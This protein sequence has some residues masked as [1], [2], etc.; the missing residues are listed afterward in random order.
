[1]NHGQPKDVEGECNARLYIADDYGDNEATMRCSLVPGHPPPHM[2]TCNRFTVMWNEDERAER[3]R[4][5]QELGDDELP[6]DEDGKLM[7]E[8]GCPLK[9]GSAAKRIADA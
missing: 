9:D 6:W 5:V 7:V 1:M 8:Q 4:L 3:E 2:E